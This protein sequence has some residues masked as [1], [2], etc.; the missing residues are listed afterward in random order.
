[1]DR[2][3]DRLATSRSLTVDKI[4]WS[5]DKTSTKLTQT[6]LKEGFATIESGR[7]VLDDESIVCLSTQI[8][9]LMSCRFCKS[10]EPFEY[11]TGRPQRFL[12][13]L[14]AQEIVD[15]AHNIFEV[16]PVPQESLGIVFSYMG[17][18]EPFANIR[19]VKES[20]IQLGVKF[21]QSRAT[22]STIAFDIAGIIKLA[23]EVASG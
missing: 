9:C 15:Q 22:L 6:T 8:G 13:N 2:E 21:S 16:I 17:A 7:Y 12:R 18:G 20:I 10:T 23:D 4:L 1:M 3:I 11:Y 14:S 19:S 5:S